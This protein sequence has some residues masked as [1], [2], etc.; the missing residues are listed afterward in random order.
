[1][2]VPRFVTRLA[3]LG[4]V[5]AVPVASVWAA[6]PPRSQLTGFACSPAL[7]P[8]ARAVAVDAVMRPLTGTR[9]LA[10]RFEL[11]QR[12]TGM[13][14]QTVQGGDLGVWR[15]PANPTLGRLPGD[16]WRLQ[17]S[18]YNLD[19]PFTYQFRVSFRWTGAHGKVLGTAT[20]Y[21]RT[22]R[23]RELRPDLT[24][25]SISVSSIAGH[26]KKEL[27]TAVVANQ[28]LTGAGPFQV[29]FV[30]GDSSAPTTATVS[31]LGAGKTRTLSFV[32]PLCDSTS[33]PTVTA[34]SA[35]QVDDFN[36]ANN[37]LTTVCP[38]VPSP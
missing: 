25:T 26:P 18:V 34:D 13:P 29:L 3:V 32:G 16:V 11:L 22:C 24:V 9:K 12:A 5:A 10:I 36:R 38:A 23:Q 17:K 37:Q 8:G 15:T 31:F 30:P 7:D 20:R 28:G 4:T 19:V 27:Y 21:S 35:S 2:R 14:V 1:M 6:A 33:P